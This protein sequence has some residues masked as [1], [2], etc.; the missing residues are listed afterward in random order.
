MIEST[1]KVYILENDLMPFLQTEEKPNFELTA[2]F[3]W[4]TDALAKVNEILEANIKAPLELLTKYKAYEEIAKTNKTKLV[5]E[6]F[7]T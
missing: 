6:L 5:K 2:D 1:N 3:P 4:F 7:G